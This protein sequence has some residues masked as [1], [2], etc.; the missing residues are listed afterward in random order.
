MIKTKLTF[1]GYQV[2]I[3]NSWFKDENI[4]FFKYFGFFL[5]FGTVVIPKVKG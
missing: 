2:S 3:F 5:N 4:Y 1:C